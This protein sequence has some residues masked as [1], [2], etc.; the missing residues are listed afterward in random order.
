MRFR[1]VY[2]SYKA[3]CPNFALAVL[4]TF[5]AKA[6]G[7]KHK[8]LYPWLVHNKKEE[9]D[10][11]GFHNHN[12]S[13]HNGHACAM[14][15]N[16]QRQAYSIKQ[17][18][19]IVLGTAA[20]VAALFTFGSVSLV[21]FGAAYVLLGVPVLIK[22]LS[23]IG[24]GQIFGENF[25]MGLATLGAIALGEYSE[26]VAVMLFY[27]VGEYFQELA[28][29]SSRRSIR[30]AVDLRPETV[31]V[32]RN[33]IWETVKPE[34]V[35]VGEQILIEPG[36]RVPLDAKVVFGESY[37]DNSAITG[38]SRPVKAAVG[39]ELMSGAINQ[40]G[41]LKAK[42][43][44]SVEQSAAG[45]IL[46][47]V[48]DAAK[49]K[50][51]LENFITRFARVYTPVVVGLAAMLAALPPI[52]GLG[53]FSLWLHRALLFLVIS[54]PC[55]LVLSVPMTFFAGLANASGQGVLF[56]GANRMEALAS[57]KAVVF[58]KTGTLTHGVFE[59]KTVLPADGF[60]EAE[61]LRL[62]A[63][64]EFFSP[65]PVAAAILKAAGEYAE[66]EK[67]KELAGRGVEAVV[68]GK[69]VLVGNARLLE[70]NNISLPELLEGT[71]AYVAV[72]R[73]YAGA[74]IIADSLK[75]DAKETV[76]D[77]NKII[78][79]SAILTGDAQ[80]PSIL[81]AKEVGAH[82]VFYKLLPEEKLTYMQDIRKR[83]GS[84]L[85]VGDGINDAPVLMGADAGMA[86]GT[87]GTDMAV[88]A[89]DIVLLTSELSAIPRA[90]R[91]SRRTI[92]VAR[93]NIIFAISAKSLV[94]LLGALGYASMWMAVFADVGIALLCVLNALRL[95]ERR[96][97]GR[98]LGLSA[99]S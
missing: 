80:A 76:E 48:E 7:L 14:C 85:F 35:R 10:L 71:V 32:L 54:C 28:V 58:D 55:A 81:A 6:Q 22:A 73:V 83:H 91:I 63:S 94:M 92:S 34:A 23:D 27:R 72:S 29:D 69:T 98:V 89:A 25:L 96:P 57:I 12:E 24:H 50:P 49:G 45:R 26:A 99:Q 60:N 53:E 79:Y 39:N 65:H 19:P 62:A 51:K 43:L 11:S 88:E 38:E 3:N 47:A 17:S 40:T 44:R 2:T 95:L 46:A 82:E 9:A 90:I 41:P 59:V 61:L 75:Q 86:V 42:V 84:V 93:A 68:K 13:N 77:L 67:A 33:E 15:S 56:K 97:K 8:H 87:S 36:E 31:R 74:I 4:W 5:T 78:G 37:V 30:S 20:Y 66:P 64:A 70:E 1:R 18:L 21:L 52:F 16:E